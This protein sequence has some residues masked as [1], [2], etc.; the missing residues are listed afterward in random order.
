M[1]CRS[2]TFVPRVR[3]RVDPIDCDANVDWSPENAA[4]ILNA[5]V[6][7]FD[8]V[9]CWLDEDPVAFN[10]CYFASAFGAAPCPPGNVLAHT[11]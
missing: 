1:E 3:F 5:V 7:S 2:I 8:G 6:A 10:L 11:Q 4:V 9:F